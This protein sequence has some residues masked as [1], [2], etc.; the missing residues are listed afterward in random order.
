MGLRRIL[1]LDRRRLARIATAIGV[2]FHVWDTQGQKART[3]KIPGRL[4]NV[5]SRG[6]CLQTNKTLIDGYH[7]MLDDDLEGRTPLLI[8]IPSLPNSPPWTLKARVL[9]Y[10]KVP[11]ESEFQFNV[12]LRFFDV[13]ST[14]WKQLEELIRVTSNPPS[15]SQ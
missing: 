8:D 12:G 2:E 14:E 10:N 4:A 6:G 11:R 9:W 15:P 13:S 3:R 5:S 1:G 7:L